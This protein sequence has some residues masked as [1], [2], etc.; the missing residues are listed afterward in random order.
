MQ[1]NTTRAKMG[2]RL[3]ALINWSLWA[4]SQSEHQQKVIEAGYQTL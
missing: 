4:K 3:T 2:H 1:D